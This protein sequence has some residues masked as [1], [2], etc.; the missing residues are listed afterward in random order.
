MY[1]ISDGY[2]I[3]CI[4]QRKTN[5]NLGQP[6]ELLPALNDKLTVIEWKPVNSVSQIV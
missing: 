1:H 2:I 3:D 5:W 6:A 4:V